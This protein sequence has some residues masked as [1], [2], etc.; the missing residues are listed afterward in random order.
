MA[1]NLMKPLTGLAKHA[2]AAAS[3][4][5][6][7]TRSVSLTA[8]N[9]PMARYGGRHTVTM[10][11]GDGIGPE[12]MSYVKEV[13]KHAGAPVDFET[14]TL[15]P[16]TDNYDDL[17]NAI[18]SVKR[19]GC[20]IKGNIET[21]MNR[22]DI[23]S[24]NVEM[25]NELDLFVNLIH[26]KS[27]PGIKT[28]HEDIDIVVMRQNTEGEYAMLEHES[29]DGVVESLKIITEASTERLCR[30]A[31]EWARANGRKRVTLVHKANIMKITDGLFMQVAK[32]VSADY[33][34]LEHNNMI[35]DNCC[36]QLVSNPWQFD[37]MI[38]TNLYGTIVT[39]LICGLIGGPGV[40]SGANIGPRYAVF[41]PGTRN[42]GT[43]LVGMNKANPCAML[44]ASADLLNHLK[45]DYHADLV[46][47]AVFK[48]VNVDKVHTEDLGGQ[49]TSID[50]V[51]NV[52]NHIKQATK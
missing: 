28:R 2:S 36:M 30:H 16:S 32:R 13:Y 6:V 46:R 23:K 15:D 49:A 38:L 14:V 42:T 7:T 29:V 35:I 22:P 4:Q 37:V 34:E 1:G 8:A 18:A 10:M 20:G 26:C 43:S 48:T 5:A 45:L 41:E 47:D 52:L 50:V 33:P 19:N 27:Q 51:Q 11:P 39:N 9:I 31:F 25:R 44:N 40:I 3:L 24:R 12:M 17:Y 21:K